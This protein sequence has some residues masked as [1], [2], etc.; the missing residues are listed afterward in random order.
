MDSASNCRGPTI[1]GSRASYG[2]SSGAPASH[3]EDA[4]GATASTLYTFRSV[5]SRLCL[6]G[7]ALPALAVSLLWLS[8]ADTALAD[9][10]PQI[11]AGPAITSSPASGDT[12]TA[13]ESIVVAVT[14]SE[15]VSV[16]GEPRVR[17]AIGDRDRW[18]RYDHAQQDGTVLVFAYEVKKVDADEDGISI[19]KN[20]LKLNGG[21]IADAD[22]NAANLKHPALAHQA[23]HKVSG[24]PPEPE[25][26][27]EPIQEPEPTP[28]PTQE[29]EPIQEPE[30]EE[31][32]EP[33]QEPEP[34][35]EP[36]PEPE[37]EPPQ[38]QQRVSL[39]QPSAPT[40]T[41]VRFD[42]PSKPALDVSWTAPSASGVTITGYQVRHQKSGASEWT[43]GTVLSRDT[44][45]HRLS[46]LE[47]GATYQVQVR[48]HF[49][50][51]AGGVSQPG[52]GPWSDSGEGKANS[53]PKNTG[54]I[55]ED[56]ADYL[57]RIL[58]SFHLADIFEDDDEDTLVYK[59]SAQY[60]GILR[61]IVD[62]STGEGTGEFLNPAGSQFIY[63]ARD[64]YGG[65]ISLT[66]EIAGTAN[67]TREVPENS[68][69]GT[70]VG[71]PVKGV[72]YG[73]E[74][75]THT[76]TGEASGAF[77]IDA[78]TGQITVKTGATLDYETKSSYAGKV[79]WTVQGQTATANL[80]IKVT[81]IGASKPAAP[82][83]TRTRFDEQSNPAL[84][85]AWTA[86]AVSDGLTIAGYELRYRKKGAADWTKP[87]ASALHE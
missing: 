69:E 65:H 26:T 53:P 58:H 12:Y 43:A 21:S 16:E 82:T 3:R 7:L 24:S 20:K 40:L 52:T 22:G 13:G 6:L 17:L 75:L 44:T 29:P 64:P 80:T 25:E 5:I 37:P 45:S 19:G 83:L 50:R 70:N 46:D 28:E 49:N 18:A 84:D 51:L 74:T 73:E 62:E 72:P 81:D 42:E 71:N 48:V 9:S 10:H 86:P 27:P 30:P 36:A 59:A 32:P 23:G 31:T 14:F 68:P 63:E 4:S 76:L 47:G 57:W 77:E 35:P 79:T 1:A 54:E 11:T 78:S 87:I 67:E 39:P 66:A 60:P 61:I 41:R 8:S 55:F 38:A 2:Q 85:V 15:A 56:V 34:E 33:I